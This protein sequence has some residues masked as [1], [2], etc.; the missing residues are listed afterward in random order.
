M[1]SKYFWLPVRQMAKAL[2]PGFVWQAAQSAWLAQVGRDQLRLIL[3]DVDSASELPPTVT[4]L[5][6]RGLANRLRAHILAQDFAL[7]TERKLVVNWPETPEC[8]VQFDDLFVWK[9]ED[10]NIA[11][12][13]YCLVRYDR[14]KHRS[15]HD[16]AVNLPHKSVILDINWQFVDRETFETKLGKQLDAARSYLIPKP[17]ILQEVEQLSLNWSLSTIGVHIRRGDFITTANQGLGLERYSRSICKALE[18]MG[19]DTTIYIAS[20]GTKEEISPLLREF[21]ARVINHPSLPRSSREGVRS[22]L[23]DMLLL[24]RT[25]FLILT[26]ISTFGE[27]AAFLGK[28]PYTYA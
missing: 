18:I 2:T 26:P 28:V 9:G 3:Q 14:H 7:R 24:S 22:A 5:A 10:R 6:Y 23:I 12:K 13:D 8:C 15:S 17:D 19:R 11:N 27:M 16:L 25:Q 1:I 4:Y 20:D 21:G